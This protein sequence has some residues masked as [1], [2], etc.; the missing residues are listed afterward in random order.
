MPLKRGKEKIRSR[1]LIFLLLFFNCAG[2]ITTSNFVSVKKG[3][4]RIEVVSETFF[5]DVIKNKELLEYIIE[6]I[7]S[8]FRIRVF[9][10][11]KGEPEKLLKEILLEI[12]YK[13]KVKKRLDIEDINEKSSLR[14]EIKLYGIKD[15]D[16]VIRAVIIAY[17]GKL[18]KLPYIKE[19]DIETQ[20][21]RFLVKI[22]IGPLKIGVIN[23][24]QYS[25]Q[26]LKRFLKEKNIIFTSLE[27]INRDFRAIF[28][29]PPYRK[30]KEEEIERLESIIFDGIKAIFFIDYFDIKRFKRRLK[31]VP[32]KYSYKRLLDRFGIELIPGLVLD[33]D[34]IRVSIPTRF[35][36]M[37]LGYPPIIL[38]KID[39]D[40]IDLKMERVEFP[41]PSPIIIKRDQRFSYQI[42]IRSSERSW[43]ITERFDLDPR[44]SWKETSL[45]GP[46]YL[47]VRIV[48]KNKRNELIVIS[49]SR[50]LKD[51]YISRNNN[52]EFLERVILWLIGDKRLLKIY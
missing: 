34:C 1:F 28:V 45:K 38:A 8:P 12:Y 30:V 14:K 20:L 15:R 3:E 32:V 37:F 31:P 49:N 43:L 24:E 6:R 26:E 46:F 25:Y 19:K 27:K 13:I 17:K 21:L 50:F 9:I 36:R 16:G 41:F 40:T 23:W 48:S 42:F 29:L 35:G 7:D 33:R 44:Q 18:Y 47:G 22:V 10:N 52:K 5:P 2:K 11:R 51:R 4:E 39:K